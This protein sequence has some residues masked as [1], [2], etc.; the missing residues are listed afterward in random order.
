[1]PFQ[2]DPKDVVTNAATDPTLRRKSENLKAARTL[3]RM[4]FTAAYDEEVA[5]GIPQIE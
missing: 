4:R 2:G 5:R 1:V 3:I